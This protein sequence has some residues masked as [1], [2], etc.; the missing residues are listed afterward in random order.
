MTINKIKREQKK[1]W[2]AVYAL[3]VPSI[4]VIFSASNE[5]C[6]GIASKYMDKGSFSLSALILG[7]LLLFGGIFY[8]GRKF[9]PKCSACGKS[10]TPYQLGVVVATKNCPSCG[11]NVIS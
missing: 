4:A 1:Y 11:E 2:V 10:I 9:L 3:S 6:I 8:A 5:T 7:L